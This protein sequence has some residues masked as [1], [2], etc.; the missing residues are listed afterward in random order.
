MPRASSQARAFPIVSQFLMPY[1]VRLT[2]ILPTES[3]APQSGRAGA[4]AAPQ[5]SR[6][7]TS[8]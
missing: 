4:V 2:A 5:T 7:S 6:A 3:A 1:M 8:R